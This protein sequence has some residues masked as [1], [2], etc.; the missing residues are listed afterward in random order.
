M[1]L[2]NTKTYCSIGLTAALV[3]SGIA[4]FFSLGNSSKE[5]TKEY[6]HF[7]E[8]NNSNVEYQ[9]K[10]IVGSGLPSNSD[11]YNGDS[12]INSDNMDIYF[13]ENGQWV[14]SANLNGEDAR[15]G[16]SIKSI[17]KISSNENTDT[18]VITYSDESTVSFVVTNGVDGLPGVQ[19]LPGEDGITP[20]VEIG[21]NGNFFINGRD[22]GIKATGH[23]GENGNDGRSVVFISRTYSSE[24]EVLYTIYYSDGTTST[25]TIVNGINGEVGAQGIQGPDGY[26]PDVAIGANGNWFV[27]GDDTGLPATG[28][29]GPQGDPGV[30]VVSI[31]MTSA[32]EEGCYYTITYTDGTS[33]TFMIPLGANGAR[34]ATGIKGPD[35]HTPIVTIGT[36]GNWYV[37]GS[38][39]GVAATG[40]KGPVGEE[41]YKGSKGA[42]GDYV[43]N[44]K[45]TDGHLIVTFYSG[46][47]VDAGVVSP[48]AELCTVTWKYG[49]G[50]STTTTTT[51]IKG[52]NA[53]QPSIGVQT[54]KKY[55]WNYIDAGVSR[56]WRLN[57]YAV[58][59]DMTLYG[60]L[61][62]L[63]FMVTFDPNGGTVPETI[64]YFTYG[65]EFNL[66]TPTAPS[67]D[68]LFVGWLSPDGYPSKMSGTVGT[69]FPLVLTACWGK[70]VT[71]DPGIGTCSVDKVLVGPGIRRDAVSLGVVTAPSGYL[72]D[73]YYMDVEGKS[74]PAALYSYNEYRYRWH[75]SWTG[76][77]IFCHYIPNYWKRQNYY[78]YDDPYETIDF[79]TSHNWDVNSLDYIET[80][81]YFRGLPVKY[82]HYS[83]SYGGKSFKKVH[84]DSGYQVVTGCGSV[85]TEWIYLK[86][87][88]IDD[89][90]TTWNITRYQ[91]SN[92]KLEKAVFPNGVKRI[93]E[94]AFYSSWYLTDLTLGS[95]LEYI[96][97]YAF[98]YT[99]TSSSNSKDLTITYNGT[100]AE[101]EAI[102]KDPAWRY[103]TG[104]SVVGTRTRDYT[105]IA[106]DG[107]YYLTA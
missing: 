15:D 13:K 70:Y 60:D 51:V 1:N 84:I 97:R 9:P 79:D 21:S 98:Y 95:G 56:E 19:G 4:L 102:E 20:S 74:I 30:G 49:D 83:G 16:L 14:Y 28:P 82:V 89:S 25:F 72:F 34:G 69:T 26:T 67:A 101:W 42:K 105:L 12:Y 46:L 44:V 5:N 91:F 86:D 35:G 73:Y 31:E 22:T 96:G 80:P 50:Y 81:R 75:E 45:V 55:K 87:N 18:Y 78:D 68:K 17:R 39:T 52:M 40:G 100:L 33:A 29:K 66:H 103:P 38:D 93:E 106:N 62:T 58:E 85:P 37:D 10:V 36:N 41:G 54:G 8:P 43:K 47:V 11:G 71:I 59:S 63:R 94:Y 24:Y 48:N 53:T 61:E 64:A 90:G 104:S 99:G 107:T 2:K 77:V 3:L 57:A 65:D 88:D 32:D 76:D 27:D 23:K 7:V 92:T 6:S